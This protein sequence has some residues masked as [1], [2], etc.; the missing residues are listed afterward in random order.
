MGEN[1]KQVSVRT[2]LWLL[3]SQRPNAHVTSGPRHR[4]SH[5]TLTVTFARILVLPSFPRTFEEKRDCSQSAKLTRRRT[6]IYQ[7]ISKKKRATVIW[8]SWK[9]LLKKSFKI[10]PLKVLYF[11]A[12]HSKSTGTMNCACSISEVSEEECGREQFPPG[13]LGWTKTRQWLVIIRPVPSFV[14]HE[15][16]FRVIF[17][18]PCDWLAVM[19]GWASSRNN[20]N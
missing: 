4:R 18:L 19:A 9:S 15:R 8:T 16:P 7:C 14:Q 20:L 2:W 1:A 12:Q 17:N 5:V 13:K 6:F 11:K 10:S 3:V